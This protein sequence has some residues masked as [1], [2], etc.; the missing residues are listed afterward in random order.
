MRRPTFRR[1]LRLES[2]ESREVLS[3][4]GPSAQAQYMLSMVNL[5]RTNPQAAAQ[6][7]T[8]NLDADVVATLNYYHVDLNQVRKDIA[9]APVRPPVAWNDTLAQAATKMA[10]DQAVNGFQSHI[11]SDG[12]NLETRLER[13]GYGNRVSDGENTYAYSKSV[14]HAMEAFLIDWGVAGNGHRNNLLQPNATPDQYY[15]EVG[16]AITPA[17]NAKVGPLVI[18]QD[19]GRQA[20]A[21]ADVLGVAYWDNDGSNSYSQGEGQGNV[22]VDAIN[23]A[24]GNSVSTSTWDDGGGYQIPLDP[25]QYTIQAKLNGKVIASNQVSVGNQNIQIDYNLTAV[26]ANNLAPATPAVK[27]QVAAPSTTGG[28]ADT[29]ASFASSWSSWTV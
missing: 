16:I 13:V 19:F 25:G 17:Q 10:T 8:T 1:T 18:T 27:A 3:G 23:N 28:T 26:S 4:G 22:E 14:D 24:T 21:K 15:K 5:A 11:G 20:N 9:S 2:L 7:F 12:S 6:K 29:N